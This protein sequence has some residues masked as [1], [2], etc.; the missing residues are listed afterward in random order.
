MIWQSRED[1]FYVFIVGRMEMEREREAPERDFWAAQ[2]FIK[3]NHLE[4]FLPSVATTGDPKAAQEEK[5]GKSYWQLARWAADLS[6]RKRW[7]NSQIP[8]MGNITRSRKD[9]L[10]LPFLEQPS[11]PVWDHYNPYFRTAE[12]LA[13]TVNQ[14]RACY[15]HYGVCIQQTS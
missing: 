9:I 4:N 10:Y 8:Q 13:W 11:P 3:T 2:V 6:S 5:K 7:L 1:D 12:Q 15:F 14:S